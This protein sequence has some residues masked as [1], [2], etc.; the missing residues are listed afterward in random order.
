MFTNV[1]P[2]HPMRTIL[3]IGAG[4]SA[5]Q[6]INYLLS[7]AA[8]ED[9]HVLLGDLSIQNAQRLINGHPKGEAI[10]LDIFDSSQRQ[11]A[12]KRA[13]IVISMLPARFHIEVAKDCITYGKSMA[14]SYTHLTL[15]TKA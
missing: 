13:T 3:I 8:T 9:L 15:P 4:K 7:K 11:A 1:Q 10:A 6:L 14:V 2:N 5:S 12:I